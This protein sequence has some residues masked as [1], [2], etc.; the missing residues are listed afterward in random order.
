MGNLKLELT[1]NSPKVILDSDKGLI[2]FEG[3]SYPENTFEFYEPIDKW[4]K[5]YFDGNTADKTIVNF[6]LT[7]FNSST[8]Q[9]IF[10][11]FD[12]ICEG[13]YKELEVN[14]FYDSKNK[15]GYEDYEDYSDE[16]PDL[17]IKAVAY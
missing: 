13:D 12:I 11:I 1:D 3:N 16:F 2:E 5:N 17:N 8:T 6:K 14:W 4:L 9:I 10:D 15:N 7:Y